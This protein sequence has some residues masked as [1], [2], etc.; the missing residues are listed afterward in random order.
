MPTELINIINL[1]NANLILYLVIFII[2]SYILISFFTWSF[3]K[4]LKYLGISNIVVG[5][6]VIIIRF[7]LNIIDVF[8]PDYIKIVEIVLPTIVKPLIVSGIVAI[9]SGILMLVVN[10][11]IN[12]YKEK[13][14]KQ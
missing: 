9:I 12:K 8:V 1:L 10:Y 11:L 13:N 14:N 3:I 7:L 2:L 6:I 4:P 5:V